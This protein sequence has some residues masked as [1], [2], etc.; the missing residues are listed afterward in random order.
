LRATADARG[1]LAPVQTLLLENDGHLIASKFGVMFDHGCKLQHFSSPPGHLRWAPPR[2]AQ[3]S[4]AT[5]PV[6]NGPAAAA[7]NR[8]RN[9]ACIFCRQHPAPQRNKAILYRATRCGDRGRRRQPHTLRKLAPARLA[10]GYLTV[11]CKR[12]RRPA[13]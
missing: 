12:L 13:K 3:I 11:H 5:C 8:A 2:R 6:C 1:E 9:R 4:F 10:E 7:A